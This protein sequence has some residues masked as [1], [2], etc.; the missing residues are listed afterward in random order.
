MHA[1]SGS[2]CSQYRGPHCKHGRQKLLC[3]D[4]LQC[5]PKPKEISN[6]PKEISSR[7]GHAEGSSPDAPITFLSD[8]CRR[9]F[10][11]AHDGMEPRRLCV[12]FTLELSCR[13]DVSTEHVTLKWVAYDCATVPAQTLINEVSIPV[14]VDKGENA[15]CTCQVLSSCSLPRP[16]PPGSYGVEAY[17]GPDQVGRVSFEVRA[18]PRRTTWHSELTYQRTEDS[19]ADVATAVAGVA[20][21]SKQAHVLNAFF[22]AGNILTVAKGAHVAWI[23]EKVVGYPKGSLIFKSQ[24][25]LGWLNEFEATVALVWFPAGTYR[26]DLTIDGVVA[27]QLPFVLQ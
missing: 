20:R 16:W 27:S 19:I 14:S 6:K 10:F 3:K 13:S 2:G 15:L 25:A 12:E 26:L 23:A 5:K 21:I 4:C 17:I 8:V 7:L 18:D 24:S 9:R 11:E 1:S 22:Q